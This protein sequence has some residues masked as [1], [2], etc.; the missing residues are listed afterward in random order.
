MPTPPESLVK[1]I[2]DDF[3][4]RGMVVTTVEVERAF[5]SEWFEGGQLSGGDWFGE[6]VGA[7]KT[8]LERTLDEQTGDGR[9]GG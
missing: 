1:R 9:S 7:V 6:R 2:V 3:A 4:K 5:A 8:R